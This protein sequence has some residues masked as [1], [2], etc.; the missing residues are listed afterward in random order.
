MPL[1]KGCHCQRGR[2]C[3]GGSANLQNCVMSF[4]DGPCVNIA[5]A[6]EIAKLFFPSSFFLLLILPSS[7]SWALTAI[8][9]STSLVRRELLL[10]DI[11]AC[12]TNFFRLL[13]DVNNLFNQ[14]KDSSTPIYDVLL[15]FRIPVTYFEE[16]GLHFMWKF[17]SKKLKASFCW[18]LDLNSGPHWKPF[19]KANGLPLS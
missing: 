6:I 4:M 2:H 19:Y 14:R 15:N 12:Q 7:S 18:L 8:A 13:V 10:P 9:T 17:M 16:L 5:T 3:Q 11:S 1:P